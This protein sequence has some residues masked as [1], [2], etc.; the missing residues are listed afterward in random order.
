MYSLDK[1]IYTPF[2]AEKKRLFYS[3]QYESLDLHCSSYALSNS[4]F[5]YTCVNWCN[6]TYDFTSYLY[7]SMLFS[8]PLSPYSFRSIKSLYYYLHLEKNN[9]I[10]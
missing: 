8:S 9:H 3:L 4:L 1:Q 7:A 10:S 6:F 5:G 2:L